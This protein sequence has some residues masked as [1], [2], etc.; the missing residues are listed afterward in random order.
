[1]DSLQTLVIQA[2]K[3]DL[4]AYTALVHRF[5]NMAVG[6][7]Y[8]ILG[9]YHLAEDAA[10]EAFVRAYL[11][12]D[13]LRDPKAFA[14]W[15]RRIVFMRC[16]R[17][18]RRKKWDTTA[19]DSNIPSPSPDPHTELETI[20]TQ[21]R[22]HQ[23]MQNL[24]EPEREVTLLYY[25][26]EHNQ[27]EIGAFLNIPTQTVKSRLH[28]ARKKLRE[29]ML[30][31]VKKNLQQERPSNG[32]N[33]EVKVIQELEDIT[34]LS[35]Q[36]IQ[37]MLRRID[38]KDLA[39]ALINVSDILQE[40]IFANISARVGHIIQEYV[41]SQMPVDEAIVA[42][43]QSIMLKIVQNLIE[44]GN[45]AWPPIHEPK[46]KQKLTKA[47]LKTKKECI[48]KLK[49]ERFEDLSCDDLTEALV[50]CAEV[51]R[52][53]GILELENIAREMPDGYFKFALRRLIDGFESGL[54]EELLTDKKKTLLQ[55]YETQ[56]D[57]IAKGVQ[58]IQQANTPGVL[59]QRL[60]VMY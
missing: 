59:R 11:E 26:G 13:Q 36:E 5:Q 42:N 38:T 12:L 1:M 4:D 3:Q 41:D 23:A 15:F 32:P 9:D 49:K 28:T 24:P 7:A 52:M 34:Q 53:E 55:Q 48:G 22:V 27:K 39:L 30:T 51:A 10:Q 58:A 45:I 56:L 19:L 6:Y 37:Q 16:N 25:I 60:Q 20:E 40:R 54:L 44:S 21:Q 50:N 18:T 33:F 29:R 8:S 2:Q 57:I 35:D 31:M 47:Y 14:G 17:I 43:K 46:S